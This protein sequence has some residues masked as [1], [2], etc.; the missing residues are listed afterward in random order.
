MPWNLGDFVLWRGCHAHERVCWDTE[1]GRGRPAWN[2]QDAAMV[3][4]HLGFSIDIACGGVDNLVR[5]HDYTLAVAEAASGEPF[6]RFWLHGGHLYVDG[7]KMSKSQGNVLYLDQLVAE[8][9]Y[10]AAV[11]FF[12]IYGAYR[13]KLN[14]T[15]EALAETSRKL[16]NC[17]A[18]IRELQNNQTANAPST[19]QA[20]KAVQN[21][22]PTF[23]KHMNKDLDAKSA[24][25]SVYATVALLVEFK[26]KKALGK[27]ELDAAVDALR[28]IDSVLQVLF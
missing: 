17:Q 24:F 3:T 1:L 2:V 27:A 6:A 23:E 20:K 26:R 12:L 16:D 7:K 5:H 18:L 4:K 28:R 13:K 8:D 10:G 14:F 21:L 15:W 9:Y 22:L 11:R 19:N 25:D